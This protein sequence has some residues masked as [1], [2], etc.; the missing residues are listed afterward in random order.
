MYD[1]CLNI[2]STVFGGI[3]A[4]SGNY[5]LEKFKQ[6]ENELKHKQLK[7]E[8]V[9][10]LLQVVLKQ[11]EKEPKSSYS[12]SNEIDEISLIL[13]LYFLDLYSEW[14]NIV[15]NISSM[16]LKISVN[17]IINFSKKIPNEII[18]K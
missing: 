4:I 12:N 16:T 9:F 5:F 8:R 17:E 7:L 1:F 14:Q 6:K 2:L 11:L 15:N 10:Y 13:R 18:D 3:I